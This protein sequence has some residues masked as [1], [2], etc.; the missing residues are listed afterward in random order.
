VDRPDSDVGIWERDDESF[1]FEKCTEVVDRRIIINISKNAPH[2][3]VKFHNDYEEKTLRKTY[4]NRVS[5]IH[6]I[7][8]CRGGI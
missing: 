7:T 1:S 8:S 4:L 2:I 5:Y 3:R 6:N